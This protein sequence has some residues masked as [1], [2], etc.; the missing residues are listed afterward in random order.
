MDKQDGL[1]GER[2]LVTALFCD[3]VGSTS[4]AEGMDPEDFSELVAAAVARMTAAVERYEGT[5]TQFSGDSILAIFGAPVAHEDD[6]YRAVR[7]GLDILTDMQSGADRVPVRV[8]INTGLMVISDMEAGTFSGY[9][10]LGDA[11]NVAARIQ[12]F[13]PENS[14]LVGSST[15]KLIAADV[16]LRDMGAHEVKGKSEPVHMFEVVGVR[17]GPTRGRGVPGLRSAM[18]GRATELETL[19][20]LLDA[21]SVGRG[22]FAAIIGEPGIGKSRLVREL[23][24]ALDEVEGAAWV[25]GRC[26]SFGARRPYHLATSLLRSLARVPDSASLDEAGA[27]VRAFA[28]RHLGAGEQRVQRLL[29][30]LGVVQ[31]APDDNPANLHI[32]Y[33]EALGDL[34]AAVCA[35][36]RPLVL[37]CEDVHWADASSSELFQSLLPRCHDLPVLGV[38]VTRPDRGT[39]GW[40]VLKTLRDEL[41]EALTELTL[42]PLAE[43]DSRALVANLLDID[44]LPE[45][46]RALILE[47]TDGNPF[48]VEEVVRTL[49]DNDLVERRGE[50]WVAKQDI[51]TLE[52]PGTVRGL[53]ASRV[54]RLSPDVRRAGMVAAV[55][56]RRFD[57][58][59]F[60]RVYAPDGAD[61]GAH[62]LLGQLEAQGFVNVAAVRPHLEMAFRHALVHDVMYET[63]L[64]SERREL[65]GQVG[66][67][68]EAMYA[69]ALDEHAPALADHF[70]HAR[71]EERARRYLL[72][73]ARGAVGRHAGREA[74][75]LF[76]RAEAFLAG[77]SAERR[78][79]RVEAAVLCT[80][81]GFTFTPLEQAL[82]VLQA[83]ADDLRALDDADLTARSNILELRLRNEGGESLMVPDYQ[84]LYQ[85]TLALTERVSDD[86]VR[87]MLLGLH[88]EALRASEDFAG[89]VEPFRA[90]IDGLE[91]SGRLAEA[92]MHCVH[93]SDCLST[94][95]RF[96]EAEQW[97]DRAEDLAQ[98]S[99]DPTAI[100]DVELGRGVTA[101]L[102]GEIDKGLDRLRLSIR[103]ADKIGNHSCSMVANF[104]AADVELK[105]NDARAALPHLDRV[106]ELATFCNSGP[107]ELLGMTW[108]TAARG[109]LGE[110]IAFD[111]PLGVARQV[112][113]R[114]GE[115]AV[116]VHRATLEA[117]KPEP[118]WDTVV[119]DFE[120]AVECFEQIQAAPY[121][122]RTLFDF[123]EALRLAGREE[124]AREEQERARGLFEELR[125]SHEPIAELRA[126]TGTD[127]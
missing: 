109:R 113:T 104:F 33:A 72:L 38:L 105:R 122:A 2:R 32:L 120:R 53:L 9:A 115:G 98:R 126:S 18:V 64:K 93:G 74:V 80:A 89:A 31:G 57:A 47:K 87:A 42:K 25:V 100:L 44:S 39:A 12:S 35:D 14:M 19:R 81:A 55:I 11:T 13:A 34:I 20:G 63:L 97:L 4:L 102:R 3:L 95:G 48:F 43:Q 1:K 29:Q 49:I 22:R 85:A 69:D 112:G 37:V 73:A 8:G 17:G 124:R 101:S 106:D 7:A 46:L 30:L 68:I 21:A 91:A 110:E 103:L 50:R 36:S 15:A 61:A 86:G 125:M 24:G 82:P 58:R 114:F 59:L 84:E 40:S 26:L 45:S 10:A 56:G 127:A 96:D 77:D 16:E 99:G 108:R 6:A 60:S 52:V 51:G 111:Q 90:A 78:R 92:A 65:H 116:L 54:D 27:G 75:D 107:F 76:R 62:P 123:G 28:E 117:T 70:E 67:A 121:V 41:G 83:R 79:E 71:D 66:A 94:T 118:D 119:A 5:V 23:A 88:A